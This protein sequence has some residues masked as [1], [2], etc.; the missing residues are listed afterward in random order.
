M[1][2]ARTSTRQYQSAHQ[3]INIHPFQNMIEAPT[4]KR[5][6]GVRPLGSIHPEVNTRYLI[7]IT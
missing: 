4:I 7:D 2:L 5:N 3:T 1:Y 6:R